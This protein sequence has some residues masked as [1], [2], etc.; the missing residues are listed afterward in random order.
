MRGT[1]T[2]NTNITQINQTNIAISA[3]PVVPIL[4]RIW[5]AAWIAI[6]IA[7]QTASH[8]KLSPSSQLKRLVPRSANGLMPD[9]IL[10]LAQSEYPVAQSPDVELASR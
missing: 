8:A 6:S 4:R 1:A 9:V 2:A 7:K 3:A 10:M 5:S